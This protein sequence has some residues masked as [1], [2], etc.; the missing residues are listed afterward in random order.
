MWTLS[1]ITAFRGDRSDVFEY[2]TSSSR[3]LESYDSINSNAGYEG[4]ATFEILITRTRRKILS[5]RFICRL[6]RF[7]A[8][9]YAI[10]KSI[11]NVH[12]TGDKLINLNSRIECNCADMS[13]ETAE[14]RHVLYKRIN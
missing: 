9:V 13:V 2:S 7:A 6:I 3:Y 5:L 8:N 12:R 1:P 14:V 11:T 10:E 4:D